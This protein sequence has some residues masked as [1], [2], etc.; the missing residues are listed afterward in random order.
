MSSIPRPYQE[1]G[2]ATTVGRFMTPTIAGIAIA[3]ASF[4][5]SSQAAAT[6]KEMAD[7][8]IRSG[9][10]TAVHNIAQADGYS[11]SSALTC[12]A[13]TDPRSFAF[14]CNMLLADE[15]RGGAPASLQF[16]IYDNNVDFNAWDANLKTAIAN[17]PT[18]N[19][20]DNDASITRTI[21]DNSSGTVKKVVTPG[22]CHQALGHPNGRALCAYLADPRIVMI[23]MVQPAHTDWDNGQ[24]I[25]EDIDHAK[26][27]A[28]VGSMLLNAA[29]Q[30]L[31][32]PMLTLDPD[33]I[34]KIMRDTAEMS[35]LI[36]RELARLNGQA[37]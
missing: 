36:D 11:G 5:T 16:L 33:Q 26:P 19:R 28:L 30:S 31:E 24:A 22:A 10:D 20:V 37:N 29:Q 7:A 21:T 13:D 17:A 27:L 9:N 23:A 12:V 15:H 34:D 8:L 4:I 25:D 3:C 35:A 18:Q 2:L 32:P 1:T 6:S 14:Q